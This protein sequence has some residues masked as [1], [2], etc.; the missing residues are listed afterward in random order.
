M[1]LGSLS[2]AGSQPISWLD[3]ALAIALTLACIN[4]WRRGLVSSI[5]SLIGLV[6][7]AYAGTHA[8]VWVVPAMNVSASARPLVSIGCVLVGSMVGS[9]LGSWAGRRLRKRLT[10]SPLRLV[11]SVGGVATEAILLCLVLW[12]IG[13]ALAVVPG[14]VSREVRN[15]RVLQSVDNGIGQFSN[16]AAGAITTG[17]TDQIVGRLVD[18]LD[19]AGTPRVFFALGGFSPRDLPAVDPSLT[20]EQKI[21]TA[22]ASVV[23][24]SGNALGCNAT[25]S[26]TGFVFGRDRI[27]T[28][29][30]VVAGVKQAMIEFPGHASRRATVIYFD[31][32]TDV[33]VL[34]V[35]TSG[36]PSLRFAGNPKR[37]QSAV[38]VG[39]PGGG[40]MAL[41]PARV[42]DVIDAR[43]SDIYG[44]VSVQRQVVVL[45]AKVRHGDSGGPLLDAAGDV[46]AVVFATS[47]DDP[48][49]GYALSAE[50]VNAARAS[51]NATPVATGRCTTAQ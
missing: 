47:V 5:F 10:W 17:I 31:P 4:G 15:S 3:V 19:N 33:A 13:S 48:N 39:Y 46:R 37:A 51:R 42:S 18:L 32:R 50:Q 45:K 27:M 29:A 6:A 38:A 34:S 16:G 12:I 26:G 7:G 1:M 30:H 44:A 22:A 2:V 9:S 21:R 49:L 35:S 20:R 14:S 36:I 24:I 28:N 25:I 8:A 23:R 41:I 11:D 43:G 40:A